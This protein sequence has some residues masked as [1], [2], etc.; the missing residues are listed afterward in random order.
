[1]QNSIRTTQYTFIKQ[2]ALLINNVCRG[3]AVTIKL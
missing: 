1:M 2:N 3:E